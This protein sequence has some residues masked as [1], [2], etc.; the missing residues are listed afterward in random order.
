MPSQPRLQSSCVAS[1]NTCCRAASIACAASAGSIRAGAPSSSGCAPCSK[2]RRCSRPPSKPPGSRLRQSP[3]PARGRLPRRS[4]LHPTRGVVLSVASRWSGSVRGA[5]D[6]TGARGWP[7]P[8]WAGRTTPGRLEAMTLRF[9]PPVAFEDPPPRTRSVQARLLSLS[10]RDSSPVGRR[11]ERWRWDRSWSRAAPHPSGR[12]RVPRTPAAEGG[13]LNTFRI[14]RLPEPW[15]A[16]SF[17]PG[18]QR[19]RGRTQRS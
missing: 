15:A 5:S 6:R 19:T 9:S 13:G 7:T 4:L 10:E 18:M 1:S 3:P 14:G 8:L 17:N 16:A 11:D 2:F 12:P